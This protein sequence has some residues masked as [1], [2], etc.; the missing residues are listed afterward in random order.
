MR[1]SSR[2]TLAGRALGIG[3]RLVGQRV[4]PPPPPPPTAAQRQA[5]AQ[6]R[7]RTGEQLGRHTRNMGRGGRNFSR[8]VWNPFAH[9]GGILWL[10]ITGMFFAL[11]ALLFVQHLWAI[12]ASWRSGPEHGHFVAYAVL[13]TLFVYFAASSFARAGKR[14]RRRRKT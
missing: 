12:R 4:L 5:A 3:L 8:A 14:S 6:Q 9:A 1:P 13:M 7:V 10:E 2:P 11:F